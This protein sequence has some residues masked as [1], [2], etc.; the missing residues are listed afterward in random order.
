MP[1]HRALY[2]HS[3]EQVI[4][5]MN[6]SETKISTGEFHGMEYLIKTRLYIPI[7]RSSTHDQMA[8]KMSLG[9][10]IKLQE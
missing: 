9:N 5:V 4:I 8:Q 7:D 3:A 6:Q 2:I 10:T 1:E